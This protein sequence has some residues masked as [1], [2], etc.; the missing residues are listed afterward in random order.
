MV[1]EILCHGRENAILGRDQRRYYDR[2]RAAH[3]PLSEEG[4]DDE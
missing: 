2:I 3:T 1:T 4:S